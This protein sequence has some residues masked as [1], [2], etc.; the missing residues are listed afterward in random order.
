LHSDS[1][2]LLTLPPLPTPFPSSPLALFTPCHLRLSLTECRLWSL[3]LPL[4]LLKAQLR[5][6]LG[7]LYEQ[8]RLIKIKIN[9][10]GA[11]LKKPALGG[12]AGG[13]KLVS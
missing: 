8:K 3:C 5:Q 6:P 2:P 12:I 9:K 11:G 13:L 10:G 1:T 4:P 7:F